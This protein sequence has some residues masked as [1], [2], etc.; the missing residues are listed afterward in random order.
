LLVEA[1]LMSLSYK[2]ATAED[3]STN[4]GMLSRENCKKIS[5]KQSVG[6][7]ERNVKVTLTQQGL[8]SPSSLEGFISYPMDPS[9]DAL[10][11]FHS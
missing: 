5:L 8:T 1:M 4:G 11:R 10:L 7:R 9:L 3:G 2:R 6:D